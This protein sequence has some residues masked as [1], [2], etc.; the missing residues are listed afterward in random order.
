MDKQ[1]NKYIAASYQLYDVTNGNAELIEQTEEGR[2]FDFIT[3]MGIVLA[4]FE[5]QLSKLSKGDKFD[6]QLTPAQAYGEHVAEHV[7]DLDKAIFT[8][9]GVFDEQRIYVDAIVPLQNEDGNRFNGHVLAIS[10]DKVKVDLN[11]PLAGKSLNFK[12][13]MLDIHEATE[14]E[15]ARF[16]NLLGGG[17]NG[18]CDGCDS[19]CG[20]HEGGCGHHEGQCN[21]HQGGCGHHEG[22]HGHHKGGCKHNH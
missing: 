7:L 2:P 16:A 4:D 10:E 6:F 22:G 3:G 12:G 17:C 18:G 8:V 21:N 19:D 14:E 5:Q 13:E 15:M 11:H 1:T 20:G 9:N